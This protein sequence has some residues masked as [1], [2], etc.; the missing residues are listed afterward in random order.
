MSH[1]GG[2]IISPIS[3]VQELNQWPL[4]LILDSIDLIKKWFIIEEK[5]RNKYWKAKS[6]AAMGNMDKI[7]T[8]RT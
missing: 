1:P 2:I 7:Q 8:G 3:G 4:Q 5:L 6:L